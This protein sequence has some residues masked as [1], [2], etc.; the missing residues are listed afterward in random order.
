MNPLG[1]ESG[2]VAYLDVTAR[3]SDGSVLSEQTY[4]RPVMVVIWCEDGTC[5]ATARP[6]TRPQQ[7][8]DTLRAIAQDMIDHP[9]GSVAERTEP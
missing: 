7:Y 6:S 9:G 4:A 3:A 5:V 8:V 2:T 1:G